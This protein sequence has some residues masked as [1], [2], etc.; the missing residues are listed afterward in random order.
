MFWVVLIL[1]ISGLF[2]FFAFVISNNPDK[3]KDENLDFLKKQWEKNITQKGVHTPIKKKVCKLLGDGEFAF[4]IVGEAFYQDN[5]CSISG[6]KQEVSKSY[7]CTA[8]ISHEPSNKYDKNAM[9]VTIQGKVVGYLD[10]DTASDFKEFIARQ[11]LMSCSF[12]VEACV[13]GGW[14]DDDSSGHY[15]VRL[16]LPDEVMDWRLV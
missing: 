13:V 16:N 4:D 3:V 5:L 14:L 15:G 1:L 10:R 7:K 2:I 8:E 11:G 12:E 9:R 6:E